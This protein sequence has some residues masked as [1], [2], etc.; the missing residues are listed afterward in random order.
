MGVVTHPDRAAQ[1]GLLVDP[2]ADALREG[3]RIVGF[4]AEECL[5]PAEDLD[6]AELA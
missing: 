4:H 2:S 3:L 5:V 6:V 1:S